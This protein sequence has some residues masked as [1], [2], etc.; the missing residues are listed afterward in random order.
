MAETP[1]LEALSSMV[2][3]LRP[4][5]ATM[6]DAIW[7]FAETKFEE[8]QSSALQISMLERHGFSVKRNAASIETAFIG[9]KG[10]GGQSSRF[11]AN[12][13]R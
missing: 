1:V 10:Q 11:W 8:Y 13:M 3:R 5:F 6:S 7:G 4:E 12:S 9:E 2:E